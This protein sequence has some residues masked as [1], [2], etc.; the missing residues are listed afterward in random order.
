MNPLDQ[1]IGILDAEIAEFKHGT[2]EQPR[3]HTPEW[4]VLRAKSLGMTYLLRVRQQ[5]LHQHQD[6]SA[7]ER[8]YRVC[9]KQFKQL[10]APP[11][12]EILREKLPQG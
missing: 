9:A 12:E 6:L 5:E 8:Y 11:A 3:E 10:V 2:K 7:A 1:A 4:Y